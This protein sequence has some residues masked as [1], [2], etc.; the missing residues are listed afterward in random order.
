MA[1]RISRIPSLGLLYSVMVGVVL[2][3]TFLIYIHI[4]G[5]DRRS[6][7][8]DVRLVRPG[9]LRGTRDFITP[10]LVVRIESAGSGSAPHVYLNSRPVAW[11]GLAPL[12]RSELK[13]RAEWFVYIEADSDVAWGDAA[14]AM[15]VIRGAGAQ[16]VLLTTPPTPS[17]ANRHR[18][19]QP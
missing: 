18:T 15:D 12:L 10:Q 7:G 16:V 4:W 11:E 19:R 8:I 1:G 9:A 5:L 2:L 3:P 14:S 6:T 13:S 17:P